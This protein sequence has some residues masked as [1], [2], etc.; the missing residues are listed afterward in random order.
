MK[1]SV[2]KTYDSGDTCTSNSCDCM[3]AVEGVLGGKPRVQLAAFSH[4]Q[5]VAATGAHGT[6]EDLVHPA[7]WPTG[8][9][10]NH[11]AA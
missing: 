11:G 1:A 5:E 6:F 8:G 9:T 10:T 2:F 3:L 7:P 4:G